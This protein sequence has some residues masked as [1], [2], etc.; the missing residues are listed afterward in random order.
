MQKLKSAIVWIL[1]D[2]WP[3]QSKTRSHFMFWKVTF[4]FLNKFS[5]VE[6]SRFSLHR[7]CKSLHFVSR[8]AL[9]KSISLQSPSKKKFSSVYECNGTE[10]QKAPLTPKPI[11]LDYYWFDGIVMIDL[12]DSFWQI[13]HL[14]LIQRDNLELL[15]FFWKIFRSKI[16]IIFG[17]WN[18]GICCKILCIL[19]EIRIFLLSDLQKNI[20]NFPRFNFIS[21]SR[22]QNFV[23]GRDEV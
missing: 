15:Q 23:C 3:Y 8:R 2:V 11:C 4:L 6:C 22:K 19:Y 14:N 12:E 16:C 7:K 9:V 10:P 18:I 17:H 1:A 13:D 5:S 20:S 21:T